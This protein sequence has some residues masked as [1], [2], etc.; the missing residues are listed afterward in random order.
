[1]FLTKT[2]RTVLFSLSLA[3]ILIITACSNSSTPPPSQG[4]DATPPPPPPPARE[5]TVVSREASSGTRGAFD[6][7]MHIR[8][9]NEDLLYA[10]AVIRESTDSVA[11]AVEVDR[12]A[13]GYTSLGSLNDAIRAIDVDGVSPTV[14]NVK[15]GEYAVARPF[16]FATLGEAEGIAADFLAFASSAEGQEIVAASGLIVSF[17]DAAPYELPSPALSGNLSLGGST[18]VERVVER[19]KDAYSSLNPEIVFEIQYV[20]SGA[21]IRDA[22]N[23]VVEIA[24][25]SRDLTAAELE[26]LTPV[27]FA[28]DGIAIIVNTQNPVQGLTSEQVTGIFTG[29]IRTWDIVE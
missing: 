23:G 25:S 9:N 11:A 14:A 22:T 29:E 7:L 16:I 19:L 5:I 3:F 6:E 2:Q 13:I 24:L 15:S 21:G 8:V 1:M 17:D 20:G 10:E 18:S 12:Y 4:N 27:V 26:V 28:N